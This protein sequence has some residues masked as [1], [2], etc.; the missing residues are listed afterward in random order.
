MARASVQS[1]FARQYISSDFANQKNSNRK[2][3]T[4]LFLAKVLYVWE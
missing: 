2:L 4:A 3:L 1:S